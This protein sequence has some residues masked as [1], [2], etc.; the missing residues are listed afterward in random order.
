M[1]G[2]VNKVSTFFFAHPKQQRKLEEAIQATQPTSSV[3]KFKDI[4]RTRW[5][6]Q[7]DAL[8]RFKDLHPSVVECFESISAEGSTNWT[9]NSLT[10]ASTVLLAIT[11]THFLSA[12]VII[13]KCLNYLLALT[14]SL[15]AEAKDIVEAVTEVDNLK[16]V[17]IDVCEN[18]DTYHGQWF[19]EVEMCDSV[20]VQPSLPRLCGR[21]SHRFN[22]PAQDP[23]E[24]YRRSVTQLQF[25]Y[26]ITFCQR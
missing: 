10:D 3:L 26:W 19:M 17:L 7:I 20:G 9:S 21:Q 5:I 8:D 11:T 13:N 24:Y 18:V 16:D 22:V 4:C 15:Q 23:P 12:L 6:E 25:Q 14:C 1:I 2:I